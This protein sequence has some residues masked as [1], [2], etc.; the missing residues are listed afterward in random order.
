MFLESQEIKVTVVKSP[1]VKVMET[2]IVEI[3][4]QSLLP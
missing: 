2:Y 4:F 3:R 1:E